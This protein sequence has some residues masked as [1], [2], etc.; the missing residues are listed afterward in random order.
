M[1]KGH[2]TIL[3]DPV[4]FTILPNVFKGILDVTD[5]TTNIPFFGNFMEFASSS[6]MY[7]V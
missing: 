3:L 7:L 1:G 5:V 4:F 2:A 6:P